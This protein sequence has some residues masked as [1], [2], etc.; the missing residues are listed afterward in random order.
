MRTLSQAQVEA[1]L[2]LIW[3]P[4]QP[5]DSTPA[6]PA[7]LAAAI[8]K[9]AADLQPEAERWETG[10]VY[11]DPG[12]PGITYRRGTGGW[13]CASHDGEYYKDG[14]LVTDE[15]RRIGFPGGGPVITGASS[16]R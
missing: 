3:L 1:A 5:P 10:A 6:A 2:V 9:V 12:L 13:S 11:A 7:E 4:G 16:R 8:F 15:F 14:E